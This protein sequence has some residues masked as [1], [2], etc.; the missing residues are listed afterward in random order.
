MEAISG[1]KDPCVKDL[2]DVNFEHL[3]QAST[4]ATTGDW[5]VYFYKEDCEGCRYLDA[6]IETLGCKH[7]GRMNVAK[8]DKGDSGAVTARRFA[9][10]ATPSFIL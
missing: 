8:M 4:G 2:T 1:Y 3:T 5:F 10:Q 7:K 6:I 9:V